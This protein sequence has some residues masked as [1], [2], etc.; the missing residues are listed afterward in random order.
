MITG[1]ARSVESRINGS[2]E[3]IVDYTFTSGNIL[4]ESIIYNYK[5]FTKADLLNRVKSR[6]EELVIS[7]Y[8]KN[9]SEEAAKIDVSDVSYQCNIA[10]AVI[11]GETLTVDD[12]KITKV[13]VANG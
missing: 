4:T 6:C 3:V 12:V 10:T 8:K 9:Q 11:D 7:E 2:L 1:Q 5:D 13:E